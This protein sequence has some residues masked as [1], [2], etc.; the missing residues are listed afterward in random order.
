MNTAYIALLRGINVS[1]HNKIKMA[2]LTQ[3]LT[4]LGF[5]NVTTYIQSGNIVFL[6]PKQQQNELENIIKEAIKKHYDFDVPVTVLNQDEFC[7]VLEHIPLESFNVSDIAEE[8]ARVGIC[9]LS[10]QPMPEAMEKL[11]SYVVEPEKL[12]INNKTAYLHCPNGF[13]KTKL[14]NN[15]IENKLK[16]S[17][18]TRNWKTVVKINQMLNTIQSGL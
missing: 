15:F 14:T 7:H 4:T 13:G 6:A 18:T 17:A 2:E 1:G 8:G 3:L 10:K 11:L 12:T 5:A 9:F 16:V